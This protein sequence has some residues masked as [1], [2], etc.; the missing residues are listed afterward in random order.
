MVIALAAGS[1]WLRP[2]AVAEVDPGVAFEEIAA[3]AGCRHLH[4]MVELS[5]RF[6][7]IMPWLASVGAAVAAADFDGDG[8][9]DFYCTSSGRGQPNALRNRGDGT[10]EDARAGVAC[11]NPEGAQ[12]TRCSAM[13]ITTAMRTSSWASGPR[14]INSS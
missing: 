12:C 5:P 14:T 7:N 6:A 11:G 10:F 9:T 3:R 1:L 4:S 2:R 8:R 13:W